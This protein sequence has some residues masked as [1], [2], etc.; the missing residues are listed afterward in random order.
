MELF[1]NDLSLHKQF[2][3]LN[4]FRSA[5]E[6]VMSIRNIIKRFGRELYCHRKVAYMDVTKDKKKMKQAVQCLS[7]EKQ[8]AW[9]LWII[10][11]GPFWEDDRQHSENDYIAC[12]NYVVTETGLGEAAWRLFYKIDCG[13]VSMSTSLWLSEF[14]VVDWHENED[15]KK[16]IKVPNYWDAETLTKVLETANKPLQSWEEL[17]KTAKNRCPGLT[18]SPESFEPL[19]GQPFNKG[20]ADQLLIR[21]DVL[22]KFKNCFD[23]NGKRTTQ[24]HETY[25]KYFTGKN[26]NAW[27]SDSSDTEKAKFKKDLTFSHPNVANPLFCPWH[28]KVKTLQLRI[29]FSWPIQ[30]RKPL[31]IVYVGPKITKQ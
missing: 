26:K 22:Q 29:H 28:G 24:G 9:M 20:A 6:C 14:L 17:E 1:F 16:S 11:Q 13:T 15:V 30:A 2:H 7:K 5:V 3:D 31:Y 19:R 18:F 23:E 4:T 10:R 27:F 12:K 25:Q 8:R 21:L